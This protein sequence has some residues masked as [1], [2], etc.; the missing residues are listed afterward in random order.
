MK[1]IGVAWILPLGA[2]VRVVWCGTGHQELKDIKDP[3]HYFKKSCQ[4]AA[5]LGKESEVNTK[6][7]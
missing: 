1:E 6:F 5:A 4:V 2:A 7:Y 3:I